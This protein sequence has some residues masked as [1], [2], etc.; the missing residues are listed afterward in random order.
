MANPQ[1]PSGGQSRF[2]WDRATLG[3]VYK[4]LE[5]SCN[6]EKFIALQNAYL[7]AQLEKIGRSDFETVL[8]I[9]AEIELL[10]IRDGK[11]I[12]HEVKEKRNL[13]DSPTY[14]SILEKNT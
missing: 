7:L 9:F 14:R 11:I 6:E 4:L 8:K 3:K 1:S 13:G 2:T 12:I 5:K 10:A